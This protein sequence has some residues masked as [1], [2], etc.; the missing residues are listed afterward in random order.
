MQDKRAFT[1]I[2]LLVVLVII[3][4]LVGLMLPSIETGGFHVVE[5]AVK[6]NDVAACRELLKKYRYGPKNY[7]VFFYYAVCY[8]SSDVCR[9]FIQE[10]KTPVDDATFLNAAAETGHFEV[11]KML[12]DAGAK[13]DVEQRT[14]GGQTLLH[15]AA[16]GG[17]AEICKLLLDRSAD[18]DAKN[19]YDWTPLM[20]AVSK[21]HVAACKVLLEAGAKTE[22]ANK[23]GETA[24]SLA[25]KPTSHLNNDPDRTEVLELLK[26]NE[27]LRK[28][29]E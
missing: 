21:N 10:L 24:M 1:W 27:N 17:N 28:S 11:F 8:G 22:I 25:E 7:P 9:F 29:N 3:L 12:L 4:M 26:Q 14:P 20:F 5:R 6:K 19:S 16:E 2:E 13:C 23:N 15:L 18:L